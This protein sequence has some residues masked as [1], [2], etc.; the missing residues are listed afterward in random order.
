M[1]QNTTAGSGKLLLFFIVLLPPK[2]FLSQLNENKSTENEPV[3]YILAYF[4]TLIRLI[5]DE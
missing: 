1:T 5:R 2:Y 4:K 3:P